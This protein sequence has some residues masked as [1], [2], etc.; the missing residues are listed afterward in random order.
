MEPQ[1]CL[2]VRERARLLVLFPRP[3]PFQTTNLGKIWWRKISNLQN[4]IP[5]R[6]AERRFFSGLGQCTKAGAMEPQ[7]RL[8][9]RERAR[10][11]VLFPRPFPFQTKKM[12]IIWRKMPNLQNR[13]PHRRAERRFFFWARPM[14]QGGRNGAT[15][16]P[17]R[18]RKGA[19][20]SVVSKAL[21]FSNKKI[22]DNLEKNAQSTKPN[23]AS[24][25]RATIFFLGSANAPR[26]AQWSHKAAFSCEKGR[27]C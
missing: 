25:C 5:H 4:R 8:F 7:S 6:R 11:L 26:R 24:T 2:F 10:L 12:G 19:L 21:P 27:A 3:L 14:H 22:G 23:P 13:I 17:F 16:P 1:S 20:T 18:A 9:V 15:K